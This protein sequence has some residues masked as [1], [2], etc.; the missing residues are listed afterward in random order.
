MFYHE[1][2]F[3]IPEA[4]FHGNL[5][6]LDALEGPL[7]RLSR[8]RLA[9][10]QRLDVNVPVGSSATLWHLLCAIIHCNTKN[11]LLGLRPRITR[12]SP[13]TSCE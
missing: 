7:Y 4:L 3:L 8:S 5:S 1:N 11:I 13:R 2:V 10:L 6:I 9:S 12:V